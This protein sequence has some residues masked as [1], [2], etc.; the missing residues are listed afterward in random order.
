VVIV[1]DLKVYKGPALWSRG[2]SSWLH[3]R[4]ALCFLWGMNWIYIYY[5]EESRPSLWS[6]GQSS[7]LQ[8]GDVLCGYRTEIYCASCEVQTEF[9]YVIAPTGQHLVLWLIP[10][11]FHLPL[12]WF[13][14][15]LNIQCG[16]EVIYILEH[17]WLVP[18]TTE[19]DKCLCDLPVSDFE[20]TQNSETAVK[21]LRYVLSVYGPDTR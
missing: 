8:N 7:W 14:N 18:V 13:W 21:E 16:T 19:H 10:S 1:F 20:K 6:S 4:Y 12:P 17:T 11:W 2:Q 9:I 3:N 5:V 15:S